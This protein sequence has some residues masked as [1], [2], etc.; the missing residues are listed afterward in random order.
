MAKEFVGVVEN[1]EMMDFPVL[2]VVALLESF[3]NRVGRANVPR[4]SGCR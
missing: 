4:A 3:L 1:V 2:G